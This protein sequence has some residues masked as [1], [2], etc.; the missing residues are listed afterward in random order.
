MHA[1]SNSNKTAWHR[2]NTISAI[3][4]IR[5]H[6]I[7]AGCVCVS[8]CNWQTF[9]IIESIRIPGTRLEA[10]CYWN[11]PAA[12]CNKLLIKAIISTPINLANIQTTT[13]PRGFEC[14]VLR[15]SGKAVSDFLSKQS[16]SKWTCERTFLR[17]KGC[18]R[19]ALNPFSGKV[20][21]FATHYMALCILLRE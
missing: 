16:V 5:S 6:S 3:I 1:C 4:V 21:F 18:Q 11:G 20:F 13:T 7:S 2:S 15:F 12:V 14:A 19:I 8:A 10:G 17:G 9:I